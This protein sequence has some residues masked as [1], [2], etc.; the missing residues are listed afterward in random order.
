M[1]ARI[2]KR[3]KKATWFFLSS[4]RGGSRTAAT[5][6]MEMLVIIVNDF[7]LLTIIAKCS[8]L[9]VA[10][11]LDLPLSVITKNSLGKIWATKIHEKS[12]WITKIETRMLFQQYTYGLYSSSPSG[13]Q[14]I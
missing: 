10:P 2:T 5:S 6:K 8:I 7:Q 13:Q 14:D 9:D 3:R 1:L 11:V 12:S 4:V